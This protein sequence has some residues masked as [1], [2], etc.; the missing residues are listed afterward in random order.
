MRRDKND[1]KWQAVKKVVKKRDKN[2]CQICKCLTRVEAEKSNKDALPITLN[3]IDPAHIYPVSLYPE[4]MYEANN[5][6]C[7]C[8][9]HHSLIDNYKDPVDGN[10]ID[11]NQVFYWWWRAKNTI[12]DKYDESL[13]YKELL[14]KEY[15]RKSSFDEFLE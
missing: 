8:R 10:S 15:K 7:L 6:M 12:T 5:I 2:I 4:I 9:H 14:K 3:V 1:E 11:E 13:D